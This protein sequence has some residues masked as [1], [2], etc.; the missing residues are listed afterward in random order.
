MKNSKL[1]PIFIFL[2]VLVSNNTQAQSV[3]SG[4]LQDRQT[5]EPLIGGHIEL[6]FTT[7]SLTYFGL[8]D[9]DGVFSIQVE[10]SGEYVMKVS[11]I[12]YET[13]NQVLV[14]ED[15]TL[16]IGTIQLNASNSMLDEIQV[17]ARQERTT[18]KGDTT[19]YNADAYASNPD[20]AA[21]DLLEKMPGFVV[22]ENGEMQVQGEKITRIL[23][24]GKPFFADDPNMALENL[25]AEIIDNIQV[26]DQQDE[27]D[28]AAGFS[29]GNTAKTVNIIL[30]EAYKNGTF[31]KVYAG[32]GLDRKYKV[33]GNLSLLNKKRRINILS[34]FNN[35]NQQNF[36]S[37]DLLG[38]SEGGKKGG[39]KRRSGSSKD[40]LVPNQGGI[41]ETNAF[42]INYQE[43]WGDK[44]E[45]TSSYFFNKS[46]NNSGSELTREFFNR[47]APFSFQEN[48][49]SNSENINH[50]F[51]A[52]IKHKFNAKNSVFVQPVLTFQKNQG[53]VIGEAE[54]FSDNNLSNSLSD[55]FKTDLTAFKF[56]NRIVYKHQLK[57]KGRS[58]VLT[59]RNT[60]D[61]SIGDR[62]ST[63]ENINF[64]NT[65]TLF[66]NQ[67]SNLNNLKKSYSTAFRFSEPLPKKSQLLIGYTIGKEDYQ[68]EIITADFDKNEEIYNLVNEELSTKFNRSYLWQ[69]GEL[70]F[71]KK[72]KKLKL[73]FRGNFQLANFS[74]KQ[75]L[76]TDNT[77]D[78]K[79]T[80]FLPSASINYKISKEK[81]FQFRYWSA[82]RLPKIQD[83]QSTI[84]NKN[85]LRLRTGNPDL[86][87]QIDHIL[88]V[89]FMANNPKKATT[90][91]AVLRANYAQDFISNNLIIA[92][93]PDTLGSIILP[94]GGQL[95][96]PVNLSGYTDARLFLNYGLPIPKL[97]SN[98]NI[99]FAYNY[100]R[101]PT[102]LD[103]IGLVTQTQKISTGLVWGSNISPSI[104]FIFKSNTSFDF[105]K[106]DF[107]NQT[108]IFSQR[109]TAKLNYIL[110][111]KWR[112]NT[113]ITH[114][115]YETFATNP[116]DDFILWNISLGFKCLK[117]Q[118][119]EFSLTLFD[120][121][122]SNINISQRFN[123][124]SLTQRSSLTL[125]RFVMLSF[126]Y[127][128]R[129][130]KK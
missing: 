59:V 13:V 91:F 114:R 46:N 22:A 10:E 76:P 23:V 112:I 56:S 52:R 35:I 15:G 58:I 65:D 81:N 51:N 101:I 68:S 77:I 103:G 121:L 111:N 45:V 100:R 18:L 12:S 106:N 118:R 36:S 29:S 49:T 85:P 50:R 130:F 66:L 24:N 16:D 83:L 53:T 1:F 48:S 70:G 69:K 117:D 6:N 86:D 93:T 41:N 14:I 47:A 119:G 43:K 127:N 94:S 7:D 54:T 4:I 67:N 110:N 61:T 96:T 20:A 33:G 42:G 124:N 90:F 107:T 126:Q 32:L 40:F 74:N 102:Q 95:R 125:K 122:N 31:G 39:N 120:I 2:T 104:D 84:D 71:S 30:K 11:Y 79:F 75:S 88:N 19:Q 115:F 63:A 72:K 25:P 116:I 60:Y 9:Y 87:Q 8:A 108:K 34:Q 78:K 57:K 17:V 80:N 62:I 123:E 73:E 37:A 129:A 128:I 89:K 5:G 82:T 28:E 92:T 64:N 105:S 3:L 26:Y 99:N 109:T 21:G 55:I 113:N 98:F 38:V 97:K 27:E 44:T